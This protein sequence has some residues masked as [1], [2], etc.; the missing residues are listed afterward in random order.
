MPKDMTRAVIE[1]TLKKAFRDVSAQPARTVRNLLD[2]AMNFSRGRFQQRFLRMAQKIMSDPE[3]AYFDLIQ[4]AVTHVDTERLTTF[5]I[6]VGYNG[7]TLGARRIR[8]I[9]AEEGFN[10]PWSLNLI[11]DEEILREKPETYV[12]IIRDAEDLGIHVFLL[13]LPEG[14]PLL[15]LP[16]LERESVSAFAVFLRGERISDAFLDRVKE[17]LNV[18][19][20]VLL[21]EQAEA[22]CVRMRERR[23]LYGVY[24]LVE[25]GTEEEILNGKFLT[26]VLPM[27]PLFAFLVSGAKCGDR[28]QQ[29]VYQY[30]LSVRNGHTYLVFLVDLRQDF[31]HIDEVISE[32][33]CVVGFNRDGSLRMYSRNASGKDYNIFQS[34]LRDIL[35]LAAAKQQPAD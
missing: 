11:L 6:N 12:S 28:T 25:D 21:N 27:R 17:T 3:S 9:E 16:L 30:V 18:M 24:R 19:L 23:L 1:V 14:D 20:C 10:I 2:L 4:D 32:D 22:A 34:S 13:S 8:Q 31:L 15:L 7:C 33:A 29:E 35:R 5:G 26:D